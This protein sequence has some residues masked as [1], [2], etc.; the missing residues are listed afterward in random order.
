M[1]LTK[2]KSARIKA[3]NFKHSKCL[4]VCLK[5]NYRSFRD[6]L[7]ASK[8]EVTM[9]LC[10]VSAVLTTIRSNELKFCMRILTSFVECFR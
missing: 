10:A 6:N 1:V 3:D 5:L 9:P 8:Y 2:R 7:K 4:K